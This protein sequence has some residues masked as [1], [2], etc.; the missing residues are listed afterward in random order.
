MQSEQV[1]KGRGGLGK[2]TRLIWAF[3]LSDVTEG[4]HNWLWTA[5]YHVGVP[6]KV[7]LKE[8]GFSCQDLRQIIC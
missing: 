7:E 8:D 1:H 5:S 2:G 3:K 6:E 4:G